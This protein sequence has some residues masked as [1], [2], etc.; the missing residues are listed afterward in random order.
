MTQGETLPVFASGNVK[1]TA[2]A[3]GVQRESPLH[4]C[5]LVSPTVN[6]IVQCHFWGK[7]TFLGVMAGAL[8]AFTYVNL[9]PKPSRAGVS[10]G[11]VM[12]L[13]VVSRLSEPEVL[14]CPATDAV[15]G[16]LALFGF[17]NYC[18]LFNY[19]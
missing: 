16:S 5:S 15:L 14:W 7:S 10:M 11:T 2:A 6:E 12:V 13:V 1:L 4:P 17:A 9:C 19:L 18:T 8:A 3:L